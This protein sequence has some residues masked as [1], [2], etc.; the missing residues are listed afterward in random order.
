MW[1]S[2]E[3]HKNVL[4]VAFERQGKKSKPFERWLRMA[5]GTVTDFHKFYQNTIQILP[6]LSKPPRV[7]NVT[8]G[9]YNISKPTTHSNPSMVDLDLKSR[10]NPNINLFGVIE[11]H[12]QF[13]SFKHQ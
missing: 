6:I 13:G 1:L 12:T 5:A 10:Q 7:Q 4:K 3:R 11:T 2:F 9:G 8:Q